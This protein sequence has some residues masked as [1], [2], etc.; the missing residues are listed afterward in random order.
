MPETVFNVL[1][2]TN[3]R[4]YITQMVQLLANQAAI[5]SYFMPD[6]NQK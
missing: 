3:Y 1:Y 6:V 2:C 5:N 4:F